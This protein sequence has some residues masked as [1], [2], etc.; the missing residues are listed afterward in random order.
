MG[1]ANIAM[2]V[3]P[4]GFCSV[5]PTVL[6]AEQARTMAKKA[7]GRVAN[8]EDPQAHKLDRR[9]KDKHTLKATVADYLA[10]QAPRGAAA[11]LYR[12]GALPHRYHISNRCIASRLIRLPARTLPAG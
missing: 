8:G 1:L 11:Y 10:D 5:R 2:A 3:P 4:V 7:L 12:A 6:G 9:G